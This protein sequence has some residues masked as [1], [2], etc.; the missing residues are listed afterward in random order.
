VGLLQES[1]LFGPLKVSQAR[2][3]LVVGVRAV[4]A[5]LVG[6]QGGRGGG[7]EDQQAKLLL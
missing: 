7:L 4:A 5:V 3:E 2:L 1:I 6:L